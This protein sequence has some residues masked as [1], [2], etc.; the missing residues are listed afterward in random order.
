MIFLFFCYI[1]SEIN[2]SLLK[3][4][5]CVTEPPSSQTHI[6]IIIHGICVCLMTCQRWLRRTEERKL[7]NW[8]EICRSLKAL[9]FWHFFLSRPQ[10]LVLLA[11]DQ[12]WNSERRQSAAGGECPPPHVFTFSSHVMSS[13]GACLI[14]FDPE[15]VVQPYGDTSNWIN[16]LQFLHFTRRNPGVTLEQL[17][18]TRERSWGSRGPLKSQTARLPAPLQSTLS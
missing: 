18:R 9:M 10:R 13:P 6:R 15:S 3:H 2:R 12:L 11:G 14:S 8:L 7:Q 1:F 5:V 4:R 16:W 17:A